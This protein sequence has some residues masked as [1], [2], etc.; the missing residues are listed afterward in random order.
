[1]SFRGLLAGL[2]RIYQ[3]L[4][5]PQLG[6]NCRFSPTCSQYSLEA[7]ERFGVIRG[8]VLGL[9]RLGKG[10][11]FHQGGFDPVPEALRR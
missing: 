4:V 8:T 2:I 9:H 11:P 6:R 10:H 5:S 1:M 7:I 3:R